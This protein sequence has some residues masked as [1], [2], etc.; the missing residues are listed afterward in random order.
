MFTHHTWQCCPVVNSQIK[1]KIKIPEL[2][3]PLQFSFTP[4]RGLFPNTV[5]CIS[6]KPFTYF[7]SSLLFGL[8]SDR[9]TLDDYN[10]PPPWLLLFFKVFFWYYLCNYSK[11]MAISPVIIKGPCSSCLEGAWR[12]PSWAAPSHSPISTSV[13]YFIDTR[14][15]KLT[16][17]GKWFCFCFQNFPVWEWNN[18]YSSW[19][20]MNN[21]YLTIAFNLSLLK[22]KPAICTL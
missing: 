6:M 3:S 13:C 10:L 20:D 15:L 21:L 19:E 11:A 22:W 14:T 16:L 2:K 5:N 17:Q 7:P 9:I 12:P 1:I 18:F 8:G 4:P